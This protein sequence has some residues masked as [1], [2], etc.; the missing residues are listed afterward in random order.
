MKRSAWLLAAALAG[1]ACSAEAATPTTGAPPAA[2]TTA[3][4]TTATTLV[5][6]E[7]EA[8]DLIDREPAFADIERGSALTVSDLATLPKEMIAVSAEG[9]VVLIDLDG[10]VLGHLPSFAPQARAGDAGLVLLGPDDALHGLDGE[11]LD[12]YP[13][14]SD[15][16]IVPSESG[17][18]WSIEHKDGASV[19]IDAFWGADD[20]GRV[21]TRNWFEGSAAYDAVSREWVDLRPGCWVADAADPDWVL[22]CRNSEM[23]ATIETLSGKVL[24]GVDEWRALYGESWPRDNE[25]YAVAGHWEELIPW[26]DRWLGEWSGECESE[27]GLLIAD[28]ALTPLEGSRR[29]EA[30]SAS[31]GGWTSAGRAVYALHGESAGCEQAADVPGVYVAELGEAPTL[32]WDSGGRT[33]E[34]R[35]L[36][37][38]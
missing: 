15:A 7:G 29:G 33:V 36:H 13:L 1:S 6:D 38:T 2:A 8:S 17:D 25:A 23:P 30:P 4:V 16:M 35:V 27:G 14:A 34:V 32:I 26:G 24:A 31:V 22:A 20:S 19:E 28:G 11:P 37:R 10:D 12:G 18:A 21:V 3:P 9:D 5:A